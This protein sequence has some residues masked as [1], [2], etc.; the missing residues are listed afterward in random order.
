MGTSLP[1]YDDLPRRDGLPCAWEV[2][3]D[4]GDVF[5]CLNLLTEERAADATRLVERG[6]TFALNWSMGLPDPPLFGR[7]PFVHHVTGDGTSTSHDDVLDNWNTQSSSQWDG[8]RHIRHHSMNR[9]TNPDATG[10]GH[11]GGVADADHGIDHWAR[12][13]IVGRGVLADIGRWR[14]AQG[15]P[16][17]YDEPDAVMPDELLA[18]LADQGTEVQEGDILLVRFGWISWYLEQD[19]DKRAWL[20]DRDAFR[21]AGFHPGEDTARTLWNLHISALRATTPASRSGH[22]DHISIRTSR[23]RRWPTRAGS[24]RSSCT[25]SCSRCSA[26]RS[27][28]CSSST[29]SLP[30]ARPTVATSA[31]SPRPRSTSRTASPAHPT[32]SPSSD[33]DDELVTLSIHIRAQTVT[34]TTPFVNWSGN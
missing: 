29:I 26:C 12:K 34:R 4:S 6:A 18:C 5:G 33:H 10:T 24:T 27:A 17:V 32:P 1:D 16:L 15:R 11:F 21:S 19:A 9:L 8:F 3:T 28:R 25:R 13:G 7:A 23:P 14:E 2:W 22:A 31:S 20:G 30:T